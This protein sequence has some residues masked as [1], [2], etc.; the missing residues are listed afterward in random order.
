MAESEN[1]R[2]RDVRPYDTAAKHLLEADPTAWLGYVGLEPTGPISVVDADLST[3]LAE[4]DKVV[5]IGG[6]SPWLVHFEIQSTYDRTM[7]ARLLQYNALLHRRH[8]LPVASVL[9]LLRREADGP[10]LTGTHG[11]AWPGSHYLTFAY[12]VVRAWEQPVERVLN[13]GL[14]TLPLAPLADLTQS[15]LPS[16]LRRVDERLATEAAPGDA[17]TVRA[18]IFLL[19]G[20]RYS[21]EDVDMIRSLGRALRESSTYQEILREGEARGEARGEAQGARRILLRAGTR[22]LGPPDPDTRAMIEAVTDIERIERMTERV[23]DA[24]NWSDVVRDD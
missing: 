24:S 21:A 4:A 5:R 1:V 18:T 11:L 16:V 7:P 3:V 6:A 8:G 19:L 23:F 10:L 2:G 15:E 22:R 13:G 9:V 12:T 20:L 14:A 17:A